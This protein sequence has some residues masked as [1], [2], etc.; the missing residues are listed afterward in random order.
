M[1]KKM[2][3]SASDVMELRRRTSAPMMECKKYLLLAN[4][5]MEEAILEMRKAGQAK[6]DKKADRVAAEGIIM[7]AEDNL[8]AVMVEV[9]C[10]TD[11]VAR[12]ENF[13]GFA[14]DV[15]QTALR[16]RL[17]DVNALSQ[18]VPSGK[19]ESIEAT[20]QVLV[21]KL[22]ENIQIR[23]AVLLNAEGAIGSYS[24]GKRIGVLVAM[25]KGEA[26]LA[27]HLA[28]HIAASKPLVVGREDVA[29][30][31]IAVEREVF[32]AQAEESGKPREI[33]EKMVEGRITKYLDEVSLSGQ[34][35]VRD[36]SKKVAQVLLEAGAVVA[37][38]HRF[39]VGEGIEKKEDNF[40]EEV[41]A[42]VRD[43]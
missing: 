4:G 17:I 13:V 39:E 27:K 31:L 3:V 20:R 6:A 9:N 30:E 42:Q 43:R 26:E 8:M 25:Q 40:V 11:F 12:D 10:E 35:Y 34:A 32:M 5:D 18:A 36:P 29:P 19:E 2:S 41:M 24:H 22:G 28:M 37:G 14:T 23:R 7:I 16:D 1:E 33:V 15:A 21:A 38:F